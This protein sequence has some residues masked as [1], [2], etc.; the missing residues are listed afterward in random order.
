[1][2]RVTI[3]GHSIQSL[4]WIDNY[5]I[6]WL[7]SGRKYDLTGE[8]G[9]IGSYHLAFPFDSAITSENGIYAF[10]YQ[11]LGTKGLL[12][13][14]GDILREINRSY[15]HA[16][17]YEYPANFVTTD[18]G[19]TYLIHCPNKYCQID[20]E[21]VETGEVITN[22]KERKP[23]DFFHSRFEISPD[24]KTLLSKGWA[25]HP[26]DFVELFNIEEC[27]L[28][29]LLLDKRC[30]PDVNAE[31]CAAS[32]INNDLVLIGA[33]NDADC[34]DDDL[35]EELINGQIAIWNIKTNTVSKPITSEFKIGGQLIA[36]DE[37]FAWDLFG[38]PK[39]VNFRT[40][41]VID[42]AEDIKSGEQISA[43]IHHL[44]YLPKMALNKKTKQIAIQNDNKI[45][46]LS[47]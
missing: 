32:F 35:F 27:I 30:S 17:V 39:I 6:D 12:L 21:N 36:I 43:I 45:E 20:F 24:N 1:M 2:K 42:K 9:T 33:A 26:I 44:D 8:I 4:S 38:F 22:I 29:P 34:F 19:V 47:K 14:N 7:D 46:F 11:K 10:V 5:L 40:G 16:D 28:N 18:D 31:I 41:V 3:Q 13:K 37:T 23:F 25:W 15:Y